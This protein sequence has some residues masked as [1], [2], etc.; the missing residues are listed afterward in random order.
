MEFPVNAPEAQKPSVAIDDASMAARIAALVQ[1]SQPGARHVRVTGVKALSGGNARRA[2]AFDVAWT[3]AA[4]PQT[5]ACVLLARLEAG[6]LET[7]MRHEFNTLS[8]LHPTGLP[9]PRPLWLD[10]D[11]LRLG[12][13]G[14]VMARGEGRAGV[15][16]LLNADSAVTKPLTEQLIRIA[17]QLH[18]LDHRKLTPSL[19]AGDGADDAPRQVLRHW[20]NQFRKQR[21]EPLPA[22]ASVF[23]WLQRNLPV[24]P[25]VAVVHG[26]LRLGNFLHANGRITLLLDWELS[27][28]GDPLEDIAWAY[29]RLWGPHDHLPITDALKVYEQAGGE[30][31]D[32]RHL[33]WHRIFAEAKFAV[34]SLT[35]ARSFI[36][37]HSNNLRMSGR[38]SM[39]NACLQQAHEWIVEQEAAR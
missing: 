3:D 4:G 29:R 27:H 12:M 39:V 2:W 36:D 35:A 20:E 31:R 6:Q 33:A 37:G 7:D 17:A 24:P 8:A 32:P 22:L 5:A 30:R 11:G 14:F 15:T 13:P 38:A 21:M 34:I 23:G 16:D 19:A 18:S 10:E 25:N 1:G 28:L 26:D 9:V